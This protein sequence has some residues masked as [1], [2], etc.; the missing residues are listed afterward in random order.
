M[1]DYERTV[2]EHYQLSTAYPVEWPAEKDN[3]DAS[4]EEE[5]VNRAPNGNI[6][7][8]KSRYSALQRAEG[9]RKSIPGSQRGDN[10]VETMVQRDEPDP[11]G[12]TDSVVRILRQLGLPV[13]E[14]PRLRNRFLMSSTTFS[15]AL[16]LS[17]VHSTASTQDLIHGL[18]VLSRSI[19]QKSAS[20][21]VLV[22]SN[23]ERFVRAK[24]TIDNVYTEMKYRGVQPPQPTLGPRSRH[25]SRTSFRA[26]SGNQAGMILAPPDARKKNALTKES[27][28]GVLGI[29]T[30]LLDVSAKAEEVWG[31][32]LGGREKEDSYKV[33]GGTVQRYK[34]LYEVGAAITDSIKRKDYES[35]VEEYAKVRRFAEDAKKLSV[36]LGDSPPTDSQ[37]YQLLLA[38]RVWN[39]VEEQIGDFK[40]DV[41]K[42]LVAM[43]NVSTRTGGMEG[44]Q[45]Q[46]MELIGVL[47]ELGVTDN[48]V[49]VW[50]LSRYDHL[51][52]KI[53]TTSERTK[54]EIEISRRRLANSERPTTH[55]IASHLR[56]LGRQTLEEKPTSVDSSEIIE[57]WEKIHTF[58]SAMLAA[59]GILG[60]V[61]EFW[62]TIQNFIDG[63]A[64]K[65]LPSGINGESRHHHRLSD[66]GILQ[67]QKGTI[68]LIDMMRESIFA[69]FSEPPI[70]DISA[71]FSPL[72][73]TPRTPVFSGAGSLTPSAL[74]ETRFNLDPNDIPP[75][76]PRRGEAWEKHAF[77][78][79]WS[80]SLS[81]VHYLGKLL[82]LVGTGASEMAAISP[83]GNGDGSALERLKSL[84]GEARERCVIAVCAAWNKDAEDI[85]VLEDWRRS[86]EK[87]DLT[88]MPAYFNA[89]ESAVLTGM[90]K[91]LYISDAMVKSDPTNI[92]FPPPTKLLQMVRSQFVT[93]LYRSLSG[94]V[95]NAEKAVKKAEDDWTTD[96]DGL[97]SPVTMMVATSIGAG[98]VDASDRN[99]RMLL[100]LSNLQALRTDVVPNL[101]TQFESAFAVK[102]TEETKTIRDVLGQIDAR[103]FQSYTRPAVNSLSA[104]IRAGISSPDWSPGSSEKPREV[105]AYVY[106]AL[107]GLVLVHTQVS[108]TASTLTAQVLSFLLEQISR[109][110]LEA[111]K[112]RQRYTLSE[113]MQ[114][115][116]DLEFVAQT[117]NQYT[118]ERASE[119][120]SQIYQEL[121][122][123]TD[124]DARSR[125]QSE[126]PEM[127]AVLKRL[128]E[129]SRSEFACFKKPRRAERPSATQSPGS[130]QPNDGQVM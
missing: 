16:F 45:D 26:S 14:D 94:M 107:L 113:L 92:V 95:E 39:D 29:K 118:T 90:Q 66:E 54:I 76:S 108:T 59:D 124:N 128:R 4:D 122:K 116:L 79:P 80:N 127:R 85:K 23:F 12:S 55:L 83:I 18:D 24:A 57:L 73:A 13:Q 34:D 121:D 109:E 58:L 22:E 129:G 15:P 33:M 130:S 5:E 126:L 11:L 110:L 56:S 53:Q 61:L 77:W 2:L 72:P 70:E 99:V 125:L 67:L 123:G 96:N 111:F 75:P 30:P 9:D 41:W 42:R 81:A 106:E 97:A 10:G 112:A 71:L 36:A 68:E 91:I 50:L 65:S 69:F 44:P 62:Q 48:P 89:F 78:P 25:A 46:H 8:S 119:I 102:L 38:A 31:P 74:R 114:A 86:P 115:T 101:T 40:R 32:A 104:I 103:L 93:T 7:N 47:L 100:T 35:V 120:Q 98:T 52:S 87:R 60:E 6:P 28:Y 1:A 21:K 64:Q 43:Q 49:W 19:D 51:K 82:V 20:L 63:K 88:R 117:L 84:V 17:Q 37:I 27:E 3:S 105:R